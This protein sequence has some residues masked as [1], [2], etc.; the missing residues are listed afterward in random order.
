LIGVVFQVIARKRL[1][2]LPSLWIATVSIIL[3]LS[4]IVEAFGEKLGLWALS[5]QGRLILGLFCGGALS[6]GSFPL[7]NHFLQK[8]DKDGSS[9]GSWHF[10]ALLVFLG[11]FSSLHFISASFL[12]V[13][14]ISVA[15]ILVCYVAANMTIAGMLV[16]W[17]K[18][19]LDLPNTLALVG[20]V[21]TLFIGEAIILG[22]MG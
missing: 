9:I 2:R 5:S 22:M 1:N 11:L 20:L 10:A 7:F 4:L 17:G 6:V 3:I 19:T 18:R 15:G 12:I 8:D 13:S 14:S 21:L 16:N